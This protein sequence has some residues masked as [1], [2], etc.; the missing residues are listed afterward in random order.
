MVAFFYTVGGLP[1]KL[2]LAFVND[3]NGTCAGYDGTRTYFNDS[4]CEF[5]LMSCRFLTEVE[6]PMIQKVRWRPKR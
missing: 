6:D 5:G 3:E 1:K 2:P 4:D